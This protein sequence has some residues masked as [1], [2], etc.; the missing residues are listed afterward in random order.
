[1]TPRQLFAFARGLLAWPDEAHWRSAVSRGYYAVFHAAGAF[2]RSLRFRV[3]GDATA[4]RYLSDR[5][6]NAGSADWDRLGQLL[7]RL[8]DDRNGADYDL[9]TA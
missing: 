2:V 4:H 3:P 8:R 5:F 9:G 6:Q 1:M 7:E